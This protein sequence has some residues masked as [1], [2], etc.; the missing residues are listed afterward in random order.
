MA[1]V[2]FKPLSR[3]RY[4]SIVN[5]VLIEGSEG[6]TKNPRK[7]RYSIQKAQQSQNQQKRP[8]VH[9][10]VKTKELPVV[11]KQKLPVEKKQTF[12]DWYFS[13]GW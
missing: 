11:E 12:L 13:L 1:A 9:V 6:V 8:I 3:G 7:I 4:R 10:V 2:T 5:G